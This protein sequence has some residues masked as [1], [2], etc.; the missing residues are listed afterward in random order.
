MN[1]RMPFIAYDEVIHDRITLAV[2]V[3]LADI[4]YEM[5]PAKPVRD[6]ASQI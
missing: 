1:L 5:T 4:Q 6:D 3:H 2:Q